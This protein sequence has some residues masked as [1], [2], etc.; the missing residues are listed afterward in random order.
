M[1][2]QQICKHLQFL[3]WVFTFSISSLVIFPNQV[4]SETTLEVQKQTT[5]F[6]M[7]LLVAGQNVS[8]DILVRSQSKEKSDQ[9][10]WLLP[11]DKV[12]QALNLQVIPLDEQ[13][14]ELRSPAQI[15]R[16]STQELKID[17]Q[18]G[19]VVSLDKLYN[20]LA[21]N[22]EVNRVDN[23][24]N[25][26]PKWLALRQ[27]LL[28]NQTMDLPNQTINDLDVIAIKPTENL[29]LGTAFGGDWHVRTY[30]PDLFDQRSLYLSEAEYLL[31]SESADY[32]IGL[33]PQS[34]LGGSRGRLLGLTTIQR[35]GFTPVT[36]DE[37]NQRRRLQAEE[38]G[39]TI[40]GKST[41]GMVVRLVKPGSTEAIAETS[42][43]SNGDYRFENVPTLGGTITKYQLLFY[44]ENATDQEPESVKT[45]SFATMSNQLPSGASALLITGGVTQEMALDQSIL[46]KT[47]NFQGLITYRYGLTE[48]LTFGINL[49]YDEELQGLGELFYQP[50]NIPLQLSLSLI[51]SPLTPGWYATTNL[52]YQPLSNLSLNLNSDRLQR[53]IA[54]NWQA[55]PNFNVSL[56][57]NNHKDEWRNHV[58]LSYQNQY[59]AAIASLEINQQEELLWSLT[60]RLGHFE[61]IYSDRVISKSGELGYNIFNLANAGYGHWLFI[62]YEDYQFQTSQSNL[63]TFGWRYRS[64]RDKDLGGFWEVGLGYGISSNGAGIV[65]STAWELVPGL[66]LELNY[67]TVSARPNEHAFS[68]KLAPNFNIFSN[69]RQW[70]F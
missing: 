34:W 49:G 20:L 58:R 59:L 63:T 41:P 3:S 52:N 68:F 44:P 31:Q 65:L 47:G 64:T 8:T 24:I 5:I 7:D 27:E 26:T 12:A 66:R 48:D 39:R 70:Q 25:L 37:F 45:V 15:T 40:A 30:Q 60:S 38:I 6:S 16:I 18:L 13:Q 17:P 32:L 46:G 1:F 55:F 10:D 14:L 56:R 21:I 53:N 35:W 57:A 23:S 11:L 19:L 43:S 4:H 28:A 29:I 36:T 50:G 61:L 51:N 54:L 67:Q 69:S 62:N 2:G 42:V 9:V 33:Q 22:S